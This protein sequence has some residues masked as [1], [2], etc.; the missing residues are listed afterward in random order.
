MRRQFTKVPVVPGIGIPECLL[1]SEANSI[2]HKPLLVYENKTLPPVSRMAFVLK[3][4]K[5]SIET[6]AIATKGGKFVL[7]NSALDRI[8]GIFKNSQIGR[9]SL[10]RLPNCIEAC[11]THSRMATLNRQL[12]FVRSPI[13]N[14]ANFS[15]PS[16]SRITI[17]NL[18]F[19]SKLF[20]RNF[21]R[22]S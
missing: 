7:L 17:N 9:M 3:G 16:K 10:P 19:M 22:A 1:T 15:P 13:I 5:R 18:A 2:C 8:A 4:L 12:R 14:P 20:D 11:F 6:V 21:K